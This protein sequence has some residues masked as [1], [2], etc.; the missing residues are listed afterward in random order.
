M[1][2]VDFFNDIRK[3]CQT[4]AD[5]A[6]VKKYQRYFRDNYDAW[7]IPHELVE[8]KVQQVTTI[9][10]VNLNFVLETAP[11]LVR[12]GKYEETSIAIQLVRHFHKDWNRATFSAVGKW[13]EI[14][15]HNWAHSDYIS[16]ELM[17]LFFKKQ[18]IDYNSFEPWQTAANKFQRRAVPVSLI[19]PLKALACFDHYLEFIEPMM[20]DPEREVH[21]GLGW[22]LRE[23]WKKQPIVVEDFLLKYKNTAPRLIFQ[24][25]TEKMDTK[26]KA[27]FKREK[28]AGKR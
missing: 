18:L 6:I 24:Y 15:I 27:Q 10:G 11:L 12:T 16:G 7:G 17:P 19:K 21:Q 5:P 26:R 1:R 13:F 20:M 8:K 9:E 28:T 3:F 23:A 2:P 4:H 14:G 25:A 22:F